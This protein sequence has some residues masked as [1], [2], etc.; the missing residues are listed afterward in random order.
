MIF[1]TEKE[2]IEWLAEAGISFESAESDSHP[3]Q[4]SNTHNFWKFS[5]TKYYITHDENDKPQTFLEAVNM[6]AERLVP[7]KLK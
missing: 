1:E 3:L 6:F 7:D 5:L 2:A 4:V